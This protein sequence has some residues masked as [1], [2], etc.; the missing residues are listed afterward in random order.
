MPSTAAITTG[1][2]FV[3]ALS[4]LAYFDYQRR[5]S[6]EF[7]RSLRHQNKKFYKQ[8]EHA[9]KESK[10]QQREEIET[11]VDQSLE[12]SPIPVDLKAREQFFIAEVSKADQL[13][14]MGSYVEAALCFY[15]ALV[16]YPQP[17]EL[18][19]MYEKTLQ[20]KEILELL[21]S[22]VVL[23]PPLEIANFIKQSLAG[24]VE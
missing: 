6:S 21:R 14:N 19:G 9:D 5:H 3:S 2:V 7:R 13:V 18:L 10:K 24:Q 11:L 17:M 23:R 4:Y 8:K 1:A 15:R 12:S 16:S 20:P 22:M